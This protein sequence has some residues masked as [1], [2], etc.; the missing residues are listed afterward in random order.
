M[1]DLRT[2][3]STSG[4]Y[5]PLWAPDKS[6]SKEKRKARARLR[7]ERRP[8]VKQRQ[9]ERRCFWTWPWGHVPVWVHDDI[10]CAVCRKDLAR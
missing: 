10:R 7:E 6:L 4:A 9:L 3:R 5:P 8:G 2:E 1:A